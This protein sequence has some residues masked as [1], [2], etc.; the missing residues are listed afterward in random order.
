MSGELVQCYN[1]GCG[2]KYELDKNTDDS[3]RHHPGEPFFHDAYKGWS[4][5]NKKCTDFTE[6]LNIKGCMVSK[7]CNVKPPEPEKLV[8][9]IPDVVAVTEVKPLQQP[10]TR[11]PYNTPMI[12]IEPEIASSVKRDFQSPTESNT[13]V[14]SAEI[15]IGTSCKNRG[16]TTIYEGPSSDSGTCTYHPGV[17]IFHEGL[18][19]WSCCQRRTTDFNAF[20]NQVGCETGQHV[21]KK[22]E[23]KSKLVRCRWDFHQTGT[24]VFVSIYAKNYSPTKSVIKLNPVRL[25]TNLIFPEESDAVF[26]L[27]A[28][29]NG[30][31]DVQKSQVNM[32]GTKVEIKMKKAEP[33]SWPKLEY[34]KTSDS[35]SQTNSPSVNDLTPKV[36][37]VDL[38]D[39]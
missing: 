12:K 19:Y 26:N 11:P 18:K 23:D 1:R 8:E 13:D 20:L 39:L 32:L 3:C 34:P 4:C 7:H 24:H 33:R 38:E 2:Q 16:C 35:K 25:Y 27:D 36:E 6:F 22:D 28:E 37:G 10:M 14:H 15:K 31:I 17:P 9:N 21:W 5:C 29:L 30:I